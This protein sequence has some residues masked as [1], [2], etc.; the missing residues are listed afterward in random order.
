MT[1]KDASDEDCGLGTDELLK[2]LKFGADVI[3][4]SAGKQLSDADI[5]AIVSRTAPI[6]A[7]VKAKA[8]AKSTNGSSSSGSSIASGNENRFLYNQKHSAIDYDPTVA[9]METR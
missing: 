6:K 3:C 2:V 4:Q 1:S 8:K 5:D 9:P 7:K